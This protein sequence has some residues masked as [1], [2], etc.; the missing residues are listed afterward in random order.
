MFEALP[1]QEGGGG[2]EVDWLARY[3]ASYVCAHTLFWQMIRSTPIKVL[4]PAPWKCLLFVSP[5]SLSLFLFFRRKIGR[6]C[7][8]PF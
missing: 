4:S 5:S 6:T 2:G 1:F 3:P 8:F 7:D